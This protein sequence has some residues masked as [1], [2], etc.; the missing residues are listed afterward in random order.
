MITILNSKLHIPELSETINREGLRALLA[1]VSQKKLTTVIAGPGY[2]KTTLVAQAV[3]SYTGEKVWYR[4]EESDQD[5]VTFVSY[6]IAGIRKI[7]PAF[8]GGVLQR[9]NSIRDPGSE[10]KDILTLLIS[11]LENQISSDLYIVLEDFHHILENQET[12]QGLDFLI[13]NLPPNLHIIIISRL[14]P[15]FSLSRFRS[16]REIVE[17]KTEDLAFTDIETDQ[18]CQK[19]FGTSLN[20]KN[21]TA[22]RQKTEG[23]VTG[24]ILFYH[25]TKGKKQSEIEKRIADLKGSF[26]V[27]SS[28]LQDN[29]FENLPVTTREFLLKT[30]IL[31]RLEVDYCNQLLKIDN[32]GEILSQ[33][34]KSQ[35]FTF[36][37]DDV[38]K[39]FYYQHLF[40][41]F[42][43]NKLM[44]MSGKKA[45]QDLQTEGAAL[46]ENKGRIEE[47]LVLYIAAEDF[48]NA[49]RL[50]Q[51]ALTIWGEE[52]RIQLI[53]SYLN[54]IPQQ[55]LEKESW[56]MTIRPYLTGKNFRDAIEELQKIYRSQEK[57]NTIEEAHQALLGMAYLHLQLGEFVQAEL[58]IKSVLEQNGLSESMK[59]YFLKVLVQTASAQGKIEETEKRYAEFLVSLEKLDGSDN[60]K[61]TLR[62]SL[63]CYKFANVGNYANSIRHGERA[64]A[65][66]VETDLY[67]EVLYC[68]ITISM[69][70]FN[71]GDYAQGFKIAK[72]GLQLLE[73]AELQNAFLSAQFLVRIAA[74]A[75]GLGEIDK[76]ITY[77]EESIQY[78]SDKN[79][80]ESALSYL[81]LGIA[82][83]T[84]GN[85][86]VA[87]E[88]LRHA[89]KVAPMKS[90]WKPI[91][92]FQLLHLD[93]E[94]YRFTDVQ[95]SIDKTKANREL[96]RSLKPNILM[97]Q[98]HYYVATGKKPAALKMFIDS[99]AI[100]EKVNA[101]PVTVG[102]SQWAIP[103]LVETYA[104]GK[105]KSYIQKNIKLLIGPW[106]NDTES[107][108]ISKSKDPLIRK[109]VIDMVK[110][111]PQKPPGDLTVNFFGKF[112]V[113][114][115]NDEIPDD[116]WKSQKA[117]NLFKYLVFKRNSGYTA[118]EILMELLWPEDDPKKTLKRFHV[119]LA[120][121]RKI[122]EPNILQGVTS[123]YIARE[124]GGYR[125]SLGENGGTDFEEFSTVLE[126]G[127]KEA[128]QETAF[129][130]FER[131]ESIYSGDFLEEDPYIEWCSQ[132][133][134]RFRND[135]LS[136][137]SWIMDYYDAEKNYD[138]CIV[139]AE[140]HLAVDAF[141]ENIYRRLMTHH[142]DNDN[143]ERAKEAY[144]RC[145]KR[146]AEGLDCSVSVETEN[147]Y[148]QIV[149]QTE[150]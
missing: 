34:E 26:T 82:K 97:L 17:I 76:A 113:R 96:W 137:L 93:I 125:L 7:S 103:L 65:L 52:G 19:L 145:K 124:G 88:N 108:S 20:E 143:L 101:P 43:T 71:Q 142:L 78:I 69:L 105:M 53:Y 149:Q 86:A 144:E 98:A 130:Y 21:V 146:L 135:Y 67:L 30:S 126:R 110:Y 4:L 55:V 75:L 148:Q 41:E 47:A 9:L 14:E 119:L 59:M 112:K 32:S 38:G 13:T 57:Q 45:V 121:L 62:S 128:H 123:S 44:D 114:A 84:A 49:C 102:V 48:E 87:E 95:N 122:L 11:E 133:R 106:I 22:L 3:R 35:L 109:A 42:L 33:L 25:A 56:Y 116:R 89:S 51:V 5:L 6:L 120:T 131:A 90:L 23:W 118:R 140:K 66:G 91:I 68:Y 111:L 72:Q 74:N 117:K 132:P 24:L 136:V 29:V 127:R 115:G 73:E 99:L 12:N 79:L 54:K 147:V 61:E 2:G 83:K 81:I 39:S 1:E 139:Y 50:A 85:L 58:K 138:S 129:A 46:Y 150:N 31:S 100:S 27:I 60:W 77:A 15:E 64:I 80:S 141:A 94:Q 92:E 10:Y 36:A 16:T 37:L 63:Q 104:Q 134:E 28:Y 70:Y 40:Q 107:K 18:F 8:G